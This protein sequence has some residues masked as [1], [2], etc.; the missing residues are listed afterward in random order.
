MFRIFISAWWSILKSLIRKE[1][2][3]MSDVLSLAFKDGAWEI[4]SILPL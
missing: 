3:S 2:S 1:N 4:I